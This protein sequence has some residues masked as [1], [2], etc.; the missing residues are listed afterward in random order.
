MYKGIAGSEGIGIGKVVIIEEHEINI[1]NK[2]VTEDMEAV[3]NVWM[4]SYKGAIFEANYVAGS[5]NSAGK[6]K[7]GRL[8]QNGCEYMIRTGKCATCY[9]CLHTFF[10]SATKLRKLF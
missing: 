10:I 1:E 5:K 2:K 3:H 4:E 7:S 6:S 9:E 8:L